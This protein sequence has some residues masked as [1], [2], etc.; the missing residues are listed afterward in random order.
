[1]RKLALYI[2]LFVALSVQPVWS[3]AAEIQISS[4]PGGQV[5]VPGEGTFSYPDGSTVNLAA[6]IIHPNYLF[7]GWSGSL[8]SAVLGDEPNKPS[9][10]MREGA[11]G[12][13]ERTVTPL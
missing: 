10:I 13:I 2:A 9:H 11:D 6:I 5:V 8:F 4:T 1:M 7:S 3:E 12:Q